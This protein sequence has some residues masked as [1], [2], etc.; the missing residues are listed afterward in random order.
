MSARKHLATA[1]GALAAATTLWPA[2][3]A[4]GVFG[5]DQGG[6]ASPS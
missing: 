2:P 5:P 3:N 4:V 1:I 6:A